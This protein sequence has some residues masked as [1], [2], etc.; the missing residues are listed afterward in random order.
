MDIFQSI[1][2]FICCGIEN[3]FYVFVYIWWM[4]HSFDYQAMK[5]LIFFLINLNIFVLYELIEIMSVR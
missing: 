2:T 4:D 1:A 3:N 5:G